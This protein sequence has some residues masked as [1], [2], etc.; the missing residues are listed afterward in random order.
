MIGRGLRVRHASGLVIAIALIM[1]GCLFAAPLKAQSLTPVE[2]EGVVLTGA[3]NYSGTFRRSGIT[4]DA[5]IVRR[6]TIRIGAQGAIST[7][8]VREVHWQGHGH[9]TQSQLCR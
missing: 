2:L 3:V 5:D 9:Q 1:G 8:V 6:F 4:Y 7:A